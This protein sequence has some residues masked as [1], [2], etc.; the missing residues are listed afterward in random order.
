MCKNNS[1]TLSLECDGRKNLEKKTLHNKKA[2]T[3][4]EFM[5]SKCCSLITSSYI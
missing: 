2:Y 5:N 1:M 4:I 3:R